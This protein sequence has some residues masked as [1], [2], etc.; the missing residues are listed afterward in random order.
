[1][2]FSTLLKHGIG[3]FPLQVTL[4]ILRGCYIHSLRAHAGAIPKYGS[5]RPR[6]A[7]PLMGFTSEKYFFMGVLFSSLRAYSI[8]RPRYLLVS[9]SST[10]SVVTIIY[11][12]REKINFSKESSSRSYSYYLRQREKKKIC[13]FNWK[14][15]NR[16]GCNSN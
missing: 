5:S 11:F 14:K 3:S 2:A 7:P 8:E 13:F 12:S 9:V 6:E 1:L 10:Q 16:T 4:I 15:S